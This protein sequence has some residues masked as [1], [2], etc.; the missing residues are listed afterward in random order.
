MTQATG[1]SRG[2]WMKSERPLDH[3][4]RL[5]AR[6]RWRPAE[7]A[8]WALAAASYFLLPDQLS[9]VS[10]MAIMGLFALSLDLLI[11]Y[12]GILSL[13]HAAHFGLGAYTAGLLGR[14]GWGEPISGLL[15][16]AVVAG[17]AGVAGGYL[18]RRGSDLTRLMVTLGISM[19]LFELANKMAW[20]TGGSDGL[21]DIVIWPILGIWEFDF[22]GRV[23]AIYSLAVLFVLFLVARRLTNSPFGLV[24]RGVRQNP[25]RMPALGSPM[26]ARI[27]AVYA[28]S[29]AL[30]GVAG[31][32][33][34]QTTQFAS[35]DVFAFH[36]SAEV[37]LMLVL[38]GTGY[39]YGGLIGAV[40]F[41]FVRN[42]LSDMTPQYWQFWMGVMFI[43][44]VL[45]GH[46]GI[47][48]MVRSGLRRL[49]RTRNAPERE[50]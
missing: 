17:L 15:A 1:L 22:Y 21:Q 40:L 3:A 9:L 29:A 47:A 23:A 7:L 4:A 34:T 2:K 46:G 10:Q 31:G 20:L 36:R 48:G 49:R 5:A 37:M 43:A 12:T 18:V 25:R 16:S 6:A 50:A 38:G 30:A 27:V 35:I 28:V 26:S 24:L 8:F 44:I 41:M 11:G 32:V 14:Y 19:M 42:L 45:A 39:L 13:G 33:L